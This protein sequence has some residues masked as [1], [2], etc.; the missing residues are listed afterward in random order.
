MPARDTIEADLR[1]LLDA[2]IGAGEIAARFFKADAQIWDKGGG[3]GPVT[4]ADLQ[5]NAH[6]EQVLCAARPDYGWMSEESAPLTDL[7]RL[8]KDNTFIVDPIDGTR[9]F[10]EGQPGFAHAMA[11][12]RHGEPVAAVVYLPMLDLTY[13]AGLGLGATLNGTPIRASS[14]KEPD[15]AQVLVARPALEAQHWPGGMPLLKR[16]F[17]PSLAWRLALIGEGR[18]DAML[19]IRDAWDWD[20]AAAALIASEAGA[21]VTDRL[22]APLRFNRENARNRGVL[23]AG[24]PLH[25][26]L[27]QGLTG[28]AMNSNPD[29]RSTGEV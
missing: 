3:Q 1:L 8:D 19:T 2:A 28:T 7:A 24:A 15:E 4:E 16:H 13:A 20:I 23:A 12:V 25:G 6:L 29:I 10:I 26:R 22:G 27:L 11:V 5:V 9:A 17:R 14:V 18:F 21:I